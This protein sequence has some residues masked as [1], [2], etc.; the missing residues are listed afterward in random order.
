M[1]VA[2]EAAEAEGGDLRG[3]QSAA[4]VVVSGQTVSSF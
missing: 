4:L 1:L 2:L 3:Q